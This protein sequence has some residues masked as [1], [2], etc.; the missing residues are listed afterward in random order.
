MRLA[1]SLYLGGLIWVLTACVAV[2]G[3]ARGVAW[4]NVPTHV[5]AVEVVQHDASAPPAFAGALRDD[6]IR[7]AALYGDAGL[8]IALRVDL[9]KVH[10]KNA[11]KAM[12]IGDDYLTK[13]RVAVVDPATG[14]P[15]GTFEIRVN[16]QRHGHL[17]ASIAMTVVEALDPT[18]YVAVG[19]MAAG[20]ASAGINRSGAEATMSANFAVE[21]LRQTFGDSRARAVHPVKR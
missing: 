20:A 21:T 8:P 16:A 19:T 3:A 5:G 13:G 9:D 18:G 10:L 14:Q 7:E 11:A 12:L 2:A 1:Q 15:L 6:I 17:G 4:A